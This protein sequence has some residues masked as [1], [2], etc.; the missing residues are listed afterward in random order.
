[1]RIEDITIIIATH[2][3]YDV[4]K[5]TIYLP[6]FVG[7]HN[8]EDIGFIKDDS[9]DNISK[10]NPYFCELTGIYW[11]WKN[12]DKHNIGLVHYRR[13]FKG[14]NKVTFNGKTKKV[15]GE[16]DV[17]NLDDN[18]I[19]LPKKRNY[20]I[21]TLYS[22]YEHTMFVEPLDLTGKIIQEDYPKY[23]KEFELLKKRKKAHMFNMFIMPKD[24]LNEYCSW[25]FDILFKLEKLVNVEQYSSFH[26]RFYGRI[27]ELLLDVWINTNGYS[28]K[29][30][31][32]VNIEKVNWTK[33]II[34]FLRAK[35][36]HQK[37]DKSF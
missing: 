7:G 20:Y 9:G 14:T 24:K 27:S 25:I 10:K 13:Y 23:F 6:L 31:P 3:K 33:K 29:E 8:K 21:E 19:Y 37:Y 2:K 28:Y 26:A 4:P 30:I 12:L 5:D 18:T 1:M 15:L 22:H 32:F 36:T 11:A 17:L 34:S 35:L 16:K